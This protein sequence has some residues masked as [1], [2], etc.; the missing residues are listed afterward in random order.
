MQIRNELWTGTRLSAKRDE[1][2]RKICLR[3]CLVPTELG[4]TS[5]AQE[6]RPCH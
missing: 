6:T 5:H 4:V 1:Y 2:C 3:V